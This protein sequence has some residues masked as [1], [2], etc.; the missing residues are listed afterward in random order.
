MFRLLKNDSP[1][2]A[3]A[4]DAVAPPDGA[5]LAMLAEHFPIGKKLRY[6]PEY[7]RDIVF[8]SIVIAWRVNDQDLYSRDAIELDADGVPQC[9]LL[10]ERRSRL[11]LAKV[12]K[13]QL[14][15][16]DTTDL[17]RSLDYVRRASLG[18]N[19]Q[20]VRGNTITLIADASQRGVPS[21]DTQVDSR[22]HMK[23]GP[24]SDN[25]MVLLRPDL[26]TLAIVD[27]RR[28]ARVHRH[29][30][31]SLYQSDD[32]PPLGC[33]LGDFSDVSLR[34]LPAAPGQALPELKPGDKVVVIFSLGDIASTFRIRG[35]VF[36]CAPEGC[37]INFRQIYKDGGYATIRTMDILEIKTGLLNLLG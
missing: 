34:L 1:P 10:G 20:F 35:A 2:G 36:R 32:K 6:Y 18:R 25:Q 13:L 19:G 23:S 33:L 3:R 15:V 37:V 8:H 24:F 4:E 28:K 11:A 12:S 26:A 14:M 9:F 5:A 30:A 22:L 29:V 31:V 16:P 27:Q 21:V 7:Q 17:E